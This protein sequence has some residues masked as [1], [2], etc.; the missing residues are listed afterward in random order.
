MI[1]QNLPRQGVVCLF[2][3]GSFFLI[4]CNENDLLE[5]NGES[6]RPLFDIEI[7]TISADS[8]LISGLPSLPMALYIDPQGNQS[9]KLHTSQ[10]GQFI[11]LL[12]SGRAPV[13]NNDLLAC[14]YPAPLVDSEPTKIMYDIRDQDGLEI[15]LYVGCAIY[16]E[17]QPKTTVDLTD[18]F[19]Q[20]VFSLEVRNKEEFE[21]LKS[22]MHHV[23]INSSLYSVRYLDA[24][25]LEETIW[26]GGIAGDAINIEAKG[27][28]MQQSQVQDSAVYRFEFLFNHFPITT[29]ET[30]EIVVRNDKNNV[31]YTCESILL[32]QSD[33]I[34]VAYQNQ[35]PSVDSDLSG[36]NYGGNLSN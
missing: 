34:Y 16:E 6:T 9:Y 11:S 4:S 33:T 31:L 7:E 15:P 23:S 36:G 29:D 2:S 1:T 24:T 8:S 25:N 22:T 19:D 26:I 35:K 30:L 21:S 5:E 32:P 3:L 10:N 12:F 14:I 13:M 17:Q 28:K 27:V 20:T 18:M